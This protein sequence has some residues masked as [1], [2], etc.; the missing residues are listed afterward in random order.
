M[1]PF[2]VNPF[3]QTGEIDEPPAP[4]FRIYRWTIASPPGVPIFKEAVH[5]THKAQL[6]L[7]VPSSMIHNNI[8]YFETDI[9]APGVS[10][11]EEWAI[12]VRN[13]RMQLLDPGHPMMK[14]S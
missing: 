12:I 11:R 4:K 8:L 5:E 10:K 9:K 1:N 7:Q 2:Q 6:A 14:K 3:I 13:A